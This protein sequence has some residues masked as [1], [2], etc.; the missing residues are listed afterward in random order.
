MQAYPP[1]H[2]SGIIK[3]VAEQLSDNSDET[4]EK[5]LI[6]VKDGINAG[7]VQTDKMLEMCRE[8]NQL[9]YD[10]LKDARDEC[11]TIAWREQGL[12]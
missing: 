7:N 2:F 11:S 4:Y 12:L 5:L 8:R 1:D 10:Q 3:Q 6:M 9:Y